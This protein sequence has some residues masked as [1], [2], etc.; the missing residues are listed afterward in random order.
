MSLQYFIYP[1]HGIFYYTINAVPELIID[2]AILI[3]VT[4]L[5]LI[6]AKTDKK[7]NRAEGIICVAAYIIYTAYIIMR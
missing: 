7:T 2:T 1:R 3:V 6:V 4:I 5:I